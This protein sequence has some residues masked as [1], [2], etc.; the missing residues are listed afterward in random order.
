MI[1]YRVTGEAEALA[2]ARKCFRDLNHVF[3][4]SRTIEPGL[5]G[6]PHGGRAGG[7]TS[8][9][10]S[11]NPI[12]VYVDFAREHGTAEEKAQ[13]HRNMLA[14]G[15]YYLHR[16]WVMNHHGNFDRIVEPAHPSAMKYLAC[17]HAAYDVTGETRFRDA[18]IKYVRQKIAS[19]GLLSLA[20]PEVR[21]QRQPL[22]LFLARGVLEQNRGGR[23]GRLDGPDADVLGSGANGPR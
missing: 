2:I 4:L 10:Q 3:D 17:V 16:N 12:L 1:R 6:K 13:A 20:R 22:L 23:C 14:H 7:T 9:D 11:A 18:A 21:S 15:D 5:L 19:S 8:F